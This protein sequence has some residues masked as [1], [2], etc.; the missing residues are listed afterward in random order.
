M[1]AA[2]VIKHFKDMGVLLDI[3][4]HKSATPRFIIA[5]CDSPGYAIRCMKDLAS[6]DMYYEGERRIDSVTSD[7]VLVSMYVNF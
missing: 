7:G 2:E 3:E 4:E 5:S 6:S 1:T